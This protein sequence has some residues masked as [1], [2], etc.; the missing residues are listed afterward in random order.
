MYSE[1]LAHVSLR[2]KFDTLYPF[3]PCSE[4]TRRRSRSC[5][6]AGMPCPNAPSPA[7]CTKRLIWPD[8]PNPFRGQPPGRWPGSRA[9]IGPTSALGCW[10][11]TT[12]LVNA[13]EEGGEAPSFGG[14]MI[15]SN[16]GEVLAES[17]QLPE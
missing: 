17:P 16:E 12:F 9:H 6:Y 3:E 2:V 10:N 5:E 15:V 13:L 8:S 11:K 1:M 4:R 7:T 14:A